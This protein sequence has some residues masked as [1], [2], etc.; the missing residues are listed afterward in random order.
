MSPKKNPQRERTEFGVYLTRLRMEKT[1]LST[2]KAAE[3]LGLKNRQQLDHY[4]TGRTMPPDS[5]LIKMAQL[6]R[7]NPDEVLRKAHWPQLILI[8]L[9]SIID[10]EQFTKDLIEEV[11]KGFEKAEREEVT[12]FIRDLLGRRMAVRQH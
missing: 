3:E 10:P 5:I 4:E 12:R 9:V 2:A 11:E 7:V 8:P 6:Y 1:N